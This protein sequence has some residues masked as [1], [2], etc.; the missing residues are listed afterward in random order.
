MLAFLAC[1]SV[2]CRATPS[3]ESA[4]SPAVAAKLEGKHWYRVSVMGQA[5]GW[6]FFENWTRTG[7]DG[8]LQLVSRQ[9]LDFRLVLN[10]Q[11]LTAA[12][13][14]TI[15]TDS[16]LRPVS[17]TMVANELGRPKNVKAQ[18][19]GSQLHVRVEGGK[20]VFTKVLDLPSDWGSDL[21]LALEAATGRLTPGRSLTASIFDP[22][23]V[24]FDRHHIKVVGWREIVVGG[25][26][27]RLLE[28]EDE[29]ER[30]K[31]RITTYLDGEGIMWRQEVPGIMNM[32]LDKVSEEEAK[33]VGQPL[34]L[35]NRVTIDRPLGDPRDL[36]L[37]VLCAKLRQPAESPFPTTDRQ[38]V[39]R[40]ENG[41]Y[42]LTL[43]GAT[44]PSERAAFPCALPET[45]AP[46]IE[47][48]SIAQAADARIRKKA[49]QV[50]AGCGDAWAA[51][52][53]IVQW[54]Y[55]NMRKVASEPRPVTAVECLEDM[56]GDCTEHALLAGALARAV[57]LP[58]KMCVGLGY[59]GD[60]FYYHAWVKIW[61]GSWVE[62]DP[63]WGEDTID[64]SHL[65]IAEGSLDE[66]SLAQMSL[67]TARVIGQLELQVLRAEPGE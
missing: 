34:S 65:Q 9:R 50:V 41:N 36:K 37:L 43:R 25:N 58:S 1:L 40:D 12:Q 21:Q 6:A 56:V 38:Q 45:L 44:A 55:K 5:S 7:E 30:L 2:G 46:F 11:H 3:V 63:T 23:L 35:T 24:D 62:M 53:A 32:V 22:Q 48:T 64:C 14:M 31:L 39:S 67:A 57:G 18:V 61:A 54:V 28:V 15:E 51:A 52:R 47:P 26:K 42:R 20:Q 60:A 29:T 17:I 16:L 59:T 19:R 33:K 4:L 27:K 49:E 10:N 8:K 13:E 66:L